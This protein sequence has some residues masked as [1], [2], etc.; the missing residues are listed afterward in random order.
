MT[1]D[2]VSKNVSQQ[3]RGRYRDVPWRRIAGLRDVLIHHYFGVD[4]ETVWQV[5]QTSLPAFK[6]QVRRI[7]SELGADL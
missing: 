4:I 7:L 5:T 6:E 1:R 2:H 3:L